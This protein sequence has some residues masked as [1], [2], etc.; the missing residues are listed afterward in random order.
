MK[1]NQLF[2]ANIPEDLF[3]KIYDCYGIK[4]LDT[5]YFFSKDDLI[6]LNT[7]D[8]LA[9]YKEELNNYYLPCKA[10]LYLNDMNVGKSITILRQLLRLFNMV[11]LSK[12]KYIKQKKTTLY[13]MIKVN[14]EIDEINAM[15]V[16]NHLIT[17]NFS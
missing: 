9:N 3:K 1:I 5:E 14:D 17:V 15:K 4:N 10:K 7:V 16:D 8:L 12:Q 2:K 13:Y 11:L 6:K